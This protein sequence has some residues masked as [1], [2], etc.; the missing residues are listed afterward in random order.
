M[1]SWL[2]QEDFLLFPQMIVWALKTMYSV[3]L[4][5][6]NNETRVLPSQ[7]LSPLNHAEQKRSSVCRQPQ[8]PE[9]V[10]TLPRAL[11]N[12]HS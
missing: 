2:T 4:L 8:P 3:L 7:Q 9:A 11:K 12:L 1:E 5:A 10:G 6:R